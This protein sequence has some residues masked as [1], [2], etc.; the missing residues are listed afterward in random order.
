MGV[1]PGTSWEHVVVIPVQRKCPGDIF[2]IIVLALVSERKPLAADVPP[3]NAHITFRTLRV[4]Y[5][6][7]NLGV[8]KDAVLI[9]PI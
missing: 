5:S 8:C 2:H 6:S 3:Y 4:Q 1:A 9:D 7:P